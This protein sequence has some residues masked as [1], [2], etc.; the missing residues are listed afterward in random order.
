LAIFE[1]ALLERDDTCFEPQLREHFLY[2][3]G[4]RRPRRFQNSDSIE[5]D[6]AFLSD[7]N[8]DDHVSLRTGGDLP[9]WITRRGRPWSQARWLLD[10]DFTELLCAGGGL[11][12][13]TSA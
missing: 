5:V 12:R 10:T 9:G 7:D 2:G 4:E 11:A 1:G 6:G 3:C 13:G 8:A